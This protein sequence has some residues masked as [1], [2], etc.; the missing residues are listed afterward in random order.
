M[1]ES[2]SRSRSPG[3]STTFGHF[4]IPGPT[5][6]VQDMGQNPYLIKPICKI[7]LLPDQNKAR[8]N[9]AWRVMWV[10]RHWAARME[11]AFLIQRSISLNRQ[12]VAKPLVSS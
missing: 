12:A 1:A 11:V 4:L 3:R 7:P 2:Y 9:K 6:K 5:P 8:I 10:M